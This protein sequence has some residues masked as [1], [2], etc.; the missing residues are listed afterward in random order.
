MRKWFL[1]LRISSKLLTGFVIVSVIAG[2]IG[3]MGIIELQTIEENSE[4]MYLMNTEPLGFISEAAIAFQRTRVNLR[5]IIIDK[6]TNDRNKYTGTIRELDRVIEDN[7][8]KFEK[9]M[10]AEDIKKE[11]ALLQ[12]NIEKFIPEREKIIS[13][14]I[15][16][17]EDEAEAFMRGEA[18]SLAQSIDTSI[19][20]LMDLKIIQAKEKNMENGKT[21]GSAATVLISIIVAG[22]IAAIGL[23][24]FISRLISKPIR[25]L[26]EAADKIASGDTNINVEA[27]SKDEV[28]ILMKSFDKMITNIREQ[29]NAVA[30]V[31]EGDLSVEVKE[32]SDNDVLSKSINKVIK[33][34]KSLIDE[35]D[36]MSRQHDAG[37]IDVTVPVEKFQGAYKSMAQGVNNM[38]NGHLTVKKKAM[39]CIA[40]FARGNFDAELEKFPGKKAFIN[41]NIEGLRKNLKDV[42][43]EITLLV[44]ASIEGKLDT[45]ANPK[46]FNGD[47]AG[48]ITG[49]NNLIDAIIEPI[50]EAAAVLQEMS[51]GNLKVSVQGDYKGDHATIKDA[52]NL[53]LKTLVAY[54]GEISGVLGEMANG[55]LDIS[56]SGDYKGDFIEIKDSLNL[57]IDSL[58]EVLSD[59]NSSAEQVA[60]GARQVS[61]SS[62]ALSQG[63]TEQA[64]SIEELTASLEEVSLQTKKNAQSAG[65]ANELAN[66]AKDNAIQGNEQMNAMLKAMEEINNSSSNISKIIKVIDEIAF[67]TN[68]LALNAAV[69]AARAGQYGKGFAVVAEEVRN[70]AARSANAA[71][72]TTVLIESSIKKVEYGTKI[73]NVTAEGLNKIV[74]GVTAAASLVGEIADASSE[75]AAAISQINQGIMQVSQVVQTNSATSEEGAAASE[76]LSSQAELLKDMV[77]RFKLK[78]S[79]IIT[80]EYAGT[81]IDGKTDGQS[82]KR[83]KHLKNTNSPQGETRVERAKIILNGNDFGKY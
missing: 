20:K 65:K 38:V 66:T 9:S 2:I 37:D 61:D 73:A 26:T 80:R 10:K 29:A 6:D 33:L 74:E 78:N 27:S 47:W 82:R 72:E 67:Q 24:V 53:T 45:R 31:A 35:M 63:S 54:I 48:L 57:I 77:R 16:G 70:L 5:D 8:S 62:Q 39:A 34:L 64:S 41:E 81:E 56:I 42:N 51:K 4:S 15:A 50:K 60:S 46:N 17:K 1:D 83:Q 71:K 19:Q 76:E 43:S 32:K 36:N 44:N 13:L 55:V 52:M 68:I 58:N 14:A 79:Q 12:S 69:E 23:G 21:A 49:L 40:E 59:I 7:L 22:I 75:Q 3:V 18:F 11:F 28:G 30:K 25:K